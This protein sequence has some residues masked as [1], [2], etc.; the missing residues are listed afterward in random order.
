M[1]IVIFG[2]S[3]SSSWGNGHATLWRGLCAALARRGHDV[4]FFER[5]VPYYAV[6]RDLVSLPDGDLILYDDWP[7]VASAARRQVSE[8][9]VAMVTSY[10]PDA[11][12]A[13]Q[14]VLESSAG[15]RCFYDLDTPITLDRLER[16]LAVDYIGPRGLR[17]FDLTLSYVGGCALSKLRSMLGAIAVAPLFG[18]VDPKAHFPV[19]CSERYRA[20]LSY[21]GTCAPDRQERLAALF[22]EPAKR[23]PDRRFVIGG[24]M[25]DDSFPWQQNIFLMSHVPVADHPSFY[26][27]SLLNLNVTRRA[28]ADNGYCPS[29]RLFEAAACGA[30]IVS[31]E[32]EG[33]DLFFEPGVEILIAK[34]SEDVIAALQRSPEELARIGRVARERALDQHTADVRAIEMENIMNSFRHVSVEVS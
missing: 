28:M 20:E 8:A 31:D 22:V 33:L 9:D 7:S 29:G 6:H 11:I 23:F 15:V 4:V 27:S 12:A 19:A 32:W 3:V 25:Y 24:S 1:K 10:C 14:L 21:L 16:G 13:S 30:T 18:S 2:L 17:D 5:D 26:C 34:Q